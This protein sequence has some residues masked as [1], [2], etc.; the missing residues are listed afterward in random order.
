[1]SREALGSEGVRHEA[2]TSE[3]LA[4]FIYGKLEI[5]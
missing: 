3:A 4:G 1:M 5:L 2:L